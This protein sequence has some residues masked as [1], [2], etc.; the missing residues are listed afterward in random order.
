MHVDRTS[1]KRIDG[2]FFFSPSVVVCEKFYHTQEN[3]AVCCFPNTFGVG[4]MGGQY[5]MGWKSLEIA[6]DE[7][8]HI[9]ERHHHLSS[10]FY[11]FW[12]SVPLMVKGR[13]AK[14]TEAR[15]GTSQLGPNPC[16]Q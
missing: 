15:F 1:E 10:I 12:T 2:T 16:Q 8:H 14:A 4:T 11:F 9:R 5:G 13:S 6:G 3:N 7:N